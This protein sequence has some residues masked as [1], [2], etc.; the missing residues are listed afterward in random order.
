M[1]WTSCDDCLSIESVCACVHA[2][3]NYI[4]QIKIQKIFIQ[5]IWLFLL[6]FLLPTD[7]FPF[8]FFFFFQFVYWKSLAI[9]HNFP[10]FSD[11]LSMISYDMSFCSYIAYIL[12][13]RFWG[14]I[15]LRFD[16]LARILQR[17]HCI[18]P[19]GYA[20]YL[21]FSI[22]YDSSDYWYSLSTLFP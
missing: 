7:H 4:V 9:C 16:F 8:L 1:S 20:L 3:V 17:T 18:L 15:W 19:S 14:L 21:A 12:V 11:C 6:N 5:C 2:C 22:S 13:V 10:Q